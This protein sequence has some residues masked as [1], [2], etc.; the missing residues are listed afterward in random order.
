VVLT[1]I[2]FLAATWCAA[3][4]KGDQASTN[5]VTGTVEKVDSD[6]KTIALKTADGTVETVKFTDKTTVH[7]LKDAAKGTD[8]AGKEGGHVIPSTPLERARTKRLIRSNGSLTRLCTRL[9]A[10]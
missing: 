10:R 4:P 3:V 9:R 1:A 6:A 5:V 8:L 7:G 2:L